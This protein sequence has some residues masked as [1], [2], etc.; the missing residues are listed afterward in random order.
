[1]RGGGKSCPNTMDA[2][3]DGDI[4]EVNTGRGFTRRQFA[5]VNLVDKKSH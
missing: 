3:T 2:S 5:I 4:I 1:M